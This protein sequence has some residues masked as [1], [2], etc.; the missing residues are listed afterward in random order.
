[1]QTENYT[2]IKLIASAGKVFDWANLEEHTHEE[3][4]PETGEKII[5]QDHLYAK[6][7]YL[8]AGDSVDNYVEVDDPAI[9][10]TKED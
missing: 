3:E 2:L 1:M 8:G 10:I 7:I 6:V 9:I 5:V 4:D